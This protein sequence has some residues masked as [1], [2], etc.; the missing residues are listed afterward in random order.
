MHLQVRNK[1]LNLD[2]KLIRYK[3]IETT[4]DSFSHTSIKIMLSHAAKKNERVPV[5]LLLQE[6]NRN[7][8]VEHSSSA[9][10]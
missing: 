6:G 9:I 1:N 7:F 2:F 10:V 5:P 4:F 8:E 3:V